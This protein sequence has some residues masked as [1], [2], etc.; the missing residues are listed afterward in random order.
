MPEFWLSTVAG[1]QTPA[2]PFVEVAGK[3]G[4]LPPLHIVNAVPKLNV[5]V[6]HGITVTFMT[7]CMPHCPELGVNV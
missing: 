4:T 3:A 2:I 1:F 7:Y 5:G 6:T